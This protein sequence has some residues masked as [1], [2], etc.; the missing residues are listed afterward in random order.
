MPK[1][2][3]PRTKASAQPPRQPAKAARPDAAHTPP[4]PTAHLNHNGNPVWTSELTFFLATVGSAIG[5]GNVWRFAWLAG[6]HGGGAFIAVYLLAVLLLGLP[7]MLAEFAVGKAGGPNPIQ[8]FRKVAP[9]GLWWLLGTMGVASCI[10]ILAYYAVI[11]GWVARYAWLALSGQLF[12]MPTEGFGPGFAAF[13]TSP[14]PVFWQALI[15]L[16][17][18]G[19]IALGVTQGIERLCK[20]LMPT[21]AITL[22]GLAIYANTLPGSS[23]GLGFLL[24]PDWSKLSHPDIYLAALGQAFF[25]LSVGYG[26]MLTYGAYAG[27]RHSLPKT[28]LFTSVGDTSFALVA[29][30]MIFPAVFAFG[31]NPASGPALAFIT[32]PQVFA[33]LPWGS[34]LAAAFFL[35]LLG[36]A[37]TSTVSMLEVGTAA[38]MQRTKLR[39]STV[40]WGLTGSIFVLGLPTALGEGP[41]AHITLFG[42]ALLDAYDAFTG[43]LLLPLTALGTAVFVGWVW[44]PAQALTAAG[45][46][47]TTWASLWQITL[48]Y[49]TPL[50]ILAIFAR[51]MGLL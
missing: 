42:H 3:K 28:A 51:S 35:L 2:S 45:L 48:R 25:S 16:V 19:I 30:L 12:P 36:A 37:I 6:E 21:L 10:I 50:A 8:A 17:T 34:A 4:A 47:G 11:T 20:I 26:V 33:Q 27:A 18:G 40:A 38:L 1:R 43:N 32:M 29:A 13:K 15:M 14:E 39:R 7:L 24:V 5:L 9:R 49:V 46:M 41:L 23:L 31:L 22:I 44:S